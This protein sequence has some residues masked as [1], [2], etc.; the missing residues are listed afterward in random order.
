MHST[1]RSPWS[2]QRTSGLPRRTPRARRGISNRR[3]AAV[4]LRPS[5][6]PCSPWSAQRISGLPRRT[7]GARRDLEPKVRGGRTPPLRPSVFFVVRA[8]N[9][10]FTT[11][12]TEG[13]ERDLELEVRGGR[14]PPL[15]PPCSSWSAQRTSGLPRRTPKARR[16]ISNRRF[17]AVELRPSVLRVLRG[18][19]SEYQVYHGGHRGHGEIS[20]RRFAAVK[21]RPSVPPCSPWSAQRISGLPRRTR[22]AREISNRRFAAVEL[23]PSVPPCS[24]W[25]AQ[26]TSGLPRRARR[27]LEPEVRGG[28]TPPLRPSVLSVVRAANQL[29]NPP[30][31]PNQPRSNLRFTSRSK[32]PATFC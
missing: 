31:L 20:N 29:P 3:F 2:A 10:R 21:L 4:E 8:A 17:A 24:P 16:G 27:D 23:R 19:R 7:R 14:T 13:T 18:P 6:P 9:I 25:S 26:R 11:E 28:R 30:T 1:A 5:V 12:G 32:N 22:R 15:R